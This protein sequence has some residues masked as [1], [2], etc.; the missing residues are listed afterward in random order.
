M[1][2]LANRATTMTLNAME[3]GFAAAVTIAAR[4]PI[5]WATLSRPSAANLGETQR[6]ISEKMEASMEG[7]LAAG[8]ALCLVWMRA[9]FGGMRK[10]ADFALAMS[11]VAAAATRP[12]HKKV[13]AN[14]KRLTRSRRAR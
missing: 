6:M 5:M 3:A 14:A 4:T 8:Q 12:A 7:G 13:R 9:A 1:T 2:P 10:P 11:D